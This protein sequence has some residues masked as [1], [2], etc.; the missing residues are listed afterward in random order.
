MIGV[1]SA[2]TGQAYK[3]PT[4]AGDSLV[5]TDTVFKAIAVTGGYSNMGIWANIKKGT[6]TLSGKLYLY[7]SM[8]GAAFILTDSASYTSASTLPTFA[9][10]TPSGYTNSAFLS[11]ASPPGVR[12]LVA[13]TQ[14]GSLTA[15][16]V[17][18]MYTLRTYQ[19]K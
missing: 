6:G 15:S 10:I 8:D 5:N 17:Q 9:G 16:P 19:I 11:K 12:Y 2:Q 18:V 13:V 4:I 3:F 14:S 1:A 7:T